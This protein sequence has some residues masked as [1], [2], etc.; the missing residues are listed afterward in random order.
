M[1]INLVTIILEKIH[2]RF[3]N[4]L[5]RLNHILGVYRKAIELARLHKINVNKAQIAALFHDY[6]KN[7]PLE[8]HLNLLP[9]HI[10][11]R[12]QKT[13][14]IYHAFSAAIV[15]E[16]EYKV[17]DKTILNAIRRHVWGYSKMNKLDKIIFI[18]DKIE[19]NRDY[20]QIDYLR[21]L[22]LENLDKTVFYI[23]ENSINFYKNKNMIIF[24][25]QLRVYE[26]FKIKLRY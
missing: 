18:S 3:K 13:P 5:F 6:T 7:E 20:P 23:L 16:Q 9:M 8:F 24:P 15:L 14:F 25:E 4:D 26:S 17:K 19:A 10:I 11:H 2:Q 21:Q 12:Y 22:A 1:S